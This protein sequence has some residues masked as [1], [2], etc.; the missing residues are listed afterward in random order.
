[1]SDSNVKFGQGGRLYSDATRDVDG[2]PW[3][4]DGSGD[5]VDP[6]PKTVVP[7]AMNP[8]ASPPASS[9]RSGSS[10][11]I[12]TILEVAGMAAFSVGFYMI[13]PSLGLIVSG[14]ALILIGVAVDRG[15]W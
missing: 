13:S 1:M 15:G 12:S 9:A 14:L 4:H 10:S 5:R 8:A 7:K 2:L 6:L 3:G 11:R